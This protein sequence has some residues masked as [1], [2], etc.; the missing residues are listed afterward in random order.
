[1]TSHVQNRNKIIVNDCPLAMCS[2]DKEIVY[3]FSL[4]AIW[5]ESYGVLFFPDLTYPRSST[6]I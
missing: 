4:T 2:R 3:H 6:K 1:M 5:I